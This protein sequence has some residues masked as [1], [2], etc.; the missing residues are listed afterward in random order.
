MALGRRLLRPF[1][2]AL[3]RT[4]GLSCSPTVRT[5]SNGPSLKYV[6]PAPAPA[7]DLSSEH[8]M[9]M[10]AAEGGLTVS[11]SEKASVPVDPFARMPT[12]DL[13]DLSSADA[14]N[15]PELVVLRSSD[16][17]T[18]ILVGLKDRC[19]SARQGVPLLAL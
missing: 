14:S 6:A 16:D 10:S 13:P 7:R 19:H 8:S 9:P 15:A 2:G 3:H 4:T 5:F 18:E 17:L 12:P 11:P 1:A